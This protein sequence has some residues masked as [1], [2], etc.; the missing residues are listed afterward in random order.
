MPTVGHDTHSRSRHPQSVTI[1]TVSHD[2]HSRSRYPQSVTTPTVSHDTHSQSRHPH[3]VTTPTVSHDAHSR[4]RCSHSVTIPTVVHYTHGSVRRRRL[5]RL[6]GTE[7]PRHSEAAPP[8]AR[9]DAQTTSPPPPGC[10]HRL[11]RPMQSDAQTTYPPYSHPGRRAITTRQTTRAVLRG[12]L[13]APATEA[14]RLLIATLVTPRGDARH[15]P[16]LL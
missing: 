9:N 6:K 8:F 4:S 15:P 10:R 2:T 5:G 3:L 13:G 14:D 7:A 1:P 11:R 12:P 16:L